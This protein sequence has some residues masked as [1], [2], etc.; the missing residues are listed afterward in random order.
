MR[1]T[2]FHSH[3]TSVGG[4]E[5]LLSTQARW[6]AAAGHDVRIVAL[7]AD[8]THC[9]THLAGLR[10]NEIGLPRGV[11]KMESLTTAMMPELIER[12]RPFL[13][14]TDV[15]MAYNYPSAPLTAAAGDT[16]RVWYACE[17]YRSLYLR[18]GNP[19][20][21]RRAER[22]GNAVHDSATL[23]VVRRLKRRGLM[24]RVM[25]W[26][27]RQQRDLKAFDGQGVC[28][29]DAVASLSHYGADCVREATGRTDTQVVYP[30][31]RFAESAP[32]R[33]GIRRMAPQILVQTRLGI[34]KNIDTLIRGFAIFR[35]VH[36]NAV[37]HVVGN[38]ARRKSL[39]KVA[40]QEAPGNVRFHGYLQQDALDALSAQCDVFAF[41]PVDE[42][43][44]MV[45]PEA[46]SRG[47][48]LV[49]SDH[50]GPREILEGGAIGELCDPFDAE[51]I[52]S[53]LKRT[54]ALTD[55]EAD[56]RRSAADASVRARFGADEV[57]R[58]LEQFLRG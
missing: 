23:Q 24:S 9:A 25:P 26:T 47:L 35:K 2:I 20:A 14:D 54:I 16:R 51:S 18:E 38:G 13:R 45:Y 4:A 57:G 44:G 17:P 30:M 29:L 34:P 22:L 40:N 41:A 48:L 1:V 53:A 12:T 21:S 37:L 3:F 36:P 33:S 31:V 32:R 15:V 58:Q 42:P 6:L 55:V 43:F 27:E 5:V 46:A 49:G 50:G 56:H 8:A 52:A 10:V 11:R 28:A 19:E 39:E 7:K